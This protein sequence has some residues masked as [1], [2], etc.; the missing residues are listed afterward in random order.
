MQITLEIL[1]EASIRL[2]SRIAQTIGVVGGLV[3]GT[4]VVEANLVSNTMIIV[5]AIT[6]ISSFIVP[7]TEMGSSIRLLGFPFMLMAAMFGLIGMSF[8]FMFLLIHLCKLESFGTPYF[9]PF[10][11]LRWSEMKDT[12]IRVPLPFFKKRPRDTLPQK[13]VKKE[14]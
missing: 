5:V 7:I 1:R 13:K 11:T 9:A 4:A 12:L 2:P 3:I 10:S 6:A 14:Q 8:F